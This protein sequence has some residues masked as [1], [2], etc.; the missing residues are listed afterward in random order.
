MSFVSREASQKVMEVLAEDKHRNW[1][2]ASLET[3]VKTRLSSSGGVVRVVINALVAAKRID[4]HVPFGKNAVPQDICWKANTGS[5]EGGATD[6]NSAN[7]IEE[8]GL[9]YNASKTKVNVL[10]TVKAELE[11]DLA[12]AIENGKKDRV[13]EVR[14]TN[15]KGE[16]K[17]TKG[18]F[19]EKFARI[20]ALAKKRKNIF[21]YGPTGCGKSY[22]ASQVADAL[23]LPF[24][25]ISCTSG[26]SEGQVIGRMAPTIPD[27]DKM[28]EHYDA[29]VKSK[30]P[31]AAAATLASAMSNGFSYV[32][33][34]FVKAYENGGV[35]L[36]DEIDACDPNVLLVINAALASD[37]MAIPNRPTQPYAIK[38]QDF[39]CMAAANTVGTGSD[40]LYAGRNKLD[41]ATLDRFLIGK[42]H[43]DY[44]RVVEG[45]LCPDD[46][47][48]NRLEAYRQGILSHRLERAMS[49]RFMIDAY[50]M[51]SDDDIGWTQ[52]DIDAA[53][54]EGW[55]EDEVNKVKQHADQNC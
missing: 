10:E 30:V 44:D 14:T 36:L 50:D 21:I 51:V 34:E 6:A 4:A 38:H 47:L 23:N 5:E 11:K 17:S 22:V 12:F 18:L 8:L 20:L 41:A 40:R 19:H 24:Y 7:I 16:T 1:T 39:V 42:L 9:K 43:M 25:F 48:R 15:D 46:T 2:Q 54:F 26:V 13:V 52:D 53:F 37:K 27:A 45:I 55:R 35:F 29:L 3:E 31:T 32:L 28:K 33:A 49:T